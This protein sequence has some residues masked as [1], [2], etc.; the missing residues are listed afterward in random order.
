VCTVFIVP[1][2][3]FFVNEKPVDCG[4]KT[5]KRPKNGLF[6]CVQA[7]VRLL[8]GTIE[9]TVELDGERRVI[10]V[11]LDGMNAGALGKPGPP[12]CVSDQADFFRPLCLA[13]KLQKGRGQM[14][15]VGDQLHSKPVIPQPSFHRTGALARRNATA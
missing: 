3:G 2:S 4:I 11:V 15:T 10:F 6:S 9:H 12:N 7:S 1:L 5:E 8:I 14:L 13:G